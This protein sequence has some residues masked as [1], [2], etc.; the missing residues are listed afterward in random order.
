MKSC[1][2]HT[3]TKQFVELPSTGARHILIAKLKWLNFKIT[4][5]INIT[6]PGDAESKSKS[7]FRV[8]FR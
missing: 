8:V 3:K 1:Y 5:G 4:Y 6:L 7:G 2:P